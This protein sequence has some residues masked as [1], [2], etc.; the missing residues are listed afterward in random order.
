[1]LIRV[2]T[3]Y[4]AD[5]KRLV[6]PQLGAFLVKSPGASVLFS[7]LMKRDDGVLR[8]LLRDAGA[9][10]LEAAGEIDRFV[11]E[12]RHAVERGEEYPLAGFGVL[13]PGPNAT[14]VFAYDPAAAGG[15]DELPDG[16]TGDSAASAA[17][18]SRTAAAGAIASDAVPSAATAG[19]ASASS[20]AESGC[21][22]CGE[23]ATPSSFAESDPEHPEAGAHAG[24]ASSEAGR[25]SSHIRPDRVADAVKSAFADAPARVSAS[26]KM[27]PEPY[28]RGLRYGKPRKTTDAYRYVDRVPRRRGLDRFLLLGILVAAVAVGAILYGWWVGR[29]AE[30]LEEPPLEQPL[31]EHSETFAEPTE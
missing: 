17:D 25:P 26:A 3:N 1:M 9:G 7:E 6:I 27:N 31:S 2:V 23:A 14:I 20:A 12:V 29:Q 10:E 15:S 18:S 8:A 19:S 28:V 13:K 11:F 5:H 30:R 16:C 24:A 22:A 4:L 21:T